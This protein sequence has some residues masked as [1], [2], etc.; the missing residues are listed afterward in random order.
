MLAA[1]LAL[2]SAGAFAGASFYVNSVEQ[3][4]RLR[5]DDEGLMKEWEDSDH[6]GFAV[7][8][9]LALAS[10]IA[11][12]IVYRTLDDI[13]WLLGAV[14]ILASWPYTYWIIVPLN[15]RI[16]DLIAAEAGAEA[17][18]MIELW[19]KLEIGLTAIGALAIGIFAW[20]AG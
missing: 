17:R 11:A 14:V 15:N 12:F 2:A 5:L 6:W 9:G 1:S 8:A 18:K 19:G 7:L 4:S 16:L 10:A 3:P 13:R 20:A